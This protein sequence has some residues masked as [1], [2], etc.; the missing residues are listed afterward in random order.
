LMEREQIE[1]KHSLKKMKH[2]SRI[3]TRDFD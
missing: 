1:D 3:F 2:T